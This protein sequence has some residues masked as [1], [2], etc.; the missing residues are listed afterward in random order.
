MEAKDRILDELAAVQAEMS[1]LKRSL[2]QAET[3]LSYASVRV[4]KLKRR[5]SA[6]LRAEREEANKSTKDNRETR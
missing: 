6:A 1:E 2:R 3:R 4:A 5:I